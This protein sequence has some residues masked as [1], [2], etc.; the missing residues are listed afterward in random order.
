MKG[1]FPHTH[2]TQ[3]RNKH[4]F[5]F[6]FLL[7]L[8]ILGGLF[9]FSRSS[10]FFHFFHLGLSEKGALSLR[11]SDASSKAHLMNSEKEDLVQEIIFLRE[12]R[13]KYAYYDTFLHFVLEERDFLLK[14]AFSKERD[15][16]TPV[17]I[18]EKDTFLNG[19]KGILAF[20]KKDTAEIGDFVY[21]SDG[22][23]LGK[24]SSISNSYSFFTPLY[25]EKDPLPLEIETSLGKISALGEGKGVDTLY[26]RIPRD[27][28]VKEGDSVFYGAYPYRHIGRIVSVLE[29]QESIEKEVYIYI[30]KIRAEDT[31][32]FIE[33][34][35]L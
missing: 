4:I 19:R 28:E 9:F 2:K 21:R 32:V 8:C 6:L 3:K 26:S 30:E 10:S 5:I 12:E 22:V 34:K 13:E 25:R 27:I 29:E 20:G 14:N 33:K 7:L 16:F 18:I 11:I 31:F 15:T 17:R 24:I 23:F 35:R 1:K